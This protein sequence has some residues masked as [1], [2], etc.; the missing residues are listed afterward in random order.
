MSKNVSIESLEQL[1]QFL[2]DNSVVEIV[3]RGKHKR[4]KQFVNVSINDITKMMEQL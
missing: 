1:K 4:Y 2:N 3:M